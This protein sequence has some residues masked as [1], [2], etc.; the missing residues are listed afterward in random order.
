MCQSLPVDI[1]AQL[2]ALGTAVVQVAQQQRERA[3]TLA[4]LEVGVRTATQAALAGLL[5][6]A[7]PLATADLDP[8]IATVRRR[9]P[10]CERL[11]GTPEQR[12]RTLRTTCGSL[13]LTRPWYHCAHCRAGF[14]PVDAALAVPPRARI[15]PALAAWL[16]RLTVAAPPR[17]AAAVLT[18]LTGLAVHPDTLREHTTAVG[19]ALADA[20]E[21]ALAR[22]QATREAAEPV[23]SAPGTLVV[24]ADGAMVRYQDGWH[25]VKLGVVGGTA[26][27]ELVAASY[28]AARESAERFGPRLLAEAA[29]RGALE[30]VAWEGPLG[31]RNLAVLRP[32]HVVGDGAHWI[33][34]LAAAHFGARTEAV[35][36]YHA[37]EHIWAVAR[38]VYGADPD[39]ARVGATVAIRALRAVG[40][41][42]VRAALAAID[43]EPAEAAA[44]VRA[45]RGYFTTNAARMDYPA[46]VARGLPIGSGAVESGAKHVVQQRMKRPGQRWSAHGARAMLALRARRASGRPYTLAA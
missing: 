34:E 17:E 40:A 35:D 24:E 21:A 27:G 3:G 32:V 1:L 13:T 2:M 33:W 25:E 28:V 8:A 20:D 7:V 41:A 18:D 39:E 36:F 45:E 31:G 22:V 15:S 6:A 23:D 37:A 9:C 42:P 30:V 38:A 5:G 14:S 26:D 10:R 4:D 19:T 16:V 43:A 12:E 29:R 11:A 46:L 44:V